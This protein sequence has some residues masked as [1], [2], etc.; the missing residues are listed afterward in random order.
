MTPLSCL[1]RLALVKWRMDVNIKP[2]ELAVLHLLLWSRGWCEFW[3]RRIFHCTSSCEPQKRKV[4]SC[5]GIPYWRNID[6]KFHKRQRRISLESHSITIEELSKEVHSLEEMN[7]YLR[8]MADA[9]VK[10]MMT[11]TQS[12][13]HAGC[14]CRCSGTQA[15]MACPQWA[16]R[17]REGERGR[18]KRKHQRFRHQSGIGVGVHSRV[19]E[20][21]VGGYES[22]DEVNGINRGE[23][24]EG[25]G[26][27]KQTL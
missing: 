4:A 15:W 20:P 22:Y 17:G 7:D 12:W 16:K 1:F 14:T 13:H 21:P 2:G 25:D 9:D 23:G 18:T 6:H 24:L 10:R 19:P 26:I 8:K 27:L 11:K 3:M 5:G